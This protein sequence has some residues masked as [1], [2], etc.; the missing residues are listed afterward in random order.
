M[1]RRAGWMYVC[2]MSVV[3]AT[4]L[5]M[6]SML[7]LDPMATRDFR[8]VPADEIA[9]LVRRLRGVAAFFFALSLLTVTAGWNG[10][11]VLQSGKSWWKRN[12]WVSWVLHVSNLL[13][14]P[15][16]ALL[17][18]RDQEPLLMIFSV[19]CLLTGA[20]VITSQRRSAAVQPDRIP[21]HLA[22]MMATGIAAHTAFLAVGAVR[23]FPNLYSYSPALYVIPWVIPAATGTVA[24]AVLKRF[25]RKGIEQ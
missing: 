5:M 7:C 21:V 16:L 11:R 23:W 13:A 24:I 4:A 25:Y 3:V 20:G 15:V 6:A 9:A 17:G 19:F 22:S 12:G 8:G 10:L 14:A 1:H 2:I 18:W